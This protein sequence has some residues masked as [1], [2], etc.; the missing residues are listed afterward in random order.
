MQSLFWLTE[1]LYPSLDT[2]LLPLL[3]ARDHEVWNLPKIQTKSWTF[4][5]W[6]TLCHLE[7]FCWLGRY[8]LINRFQKCWSR[9]CDVFQDLV[10]ATLLW[11]KTPEGRLIEGLPKRKWFG[12]KGS[13]SFISLETF[14]NG[15]E[16]I[17]DSIS[18]VNADSVSSVSVL[19]PMTLQRESLK[20][21]TNLSE[22]PP[23]CG[24]R[25]GLNFQLI[26]TS[27]MWSLDANSRED[28]RASIPFLNSE[29]E[30][31]KDF[32]LSE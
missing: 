7:R 27:M 16:F 12:V 11:K 2:L 25:G 21:W 10:T 22:L 26:S 3:E 4:K 5:F 20:T 31:T 1:L 9:I 24:A 14:V 15:R 32:P 13:G 19:E 8:S 29:Q 6:F 28:L 18:Q 30:P 17:L 23:K